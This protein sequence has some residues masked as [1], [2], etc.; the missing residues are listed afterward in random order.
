MIENEQEVIDYLKKEENKE[1]LSKNGFVTEVEKQVKTPLT[2][3]EVKGYLAG[4]PEMTKQVGATAVQAFL[5]EKLGKEVTEE[6][7]KQGLVLGGTL[8]NVKKLAIEKILSG[9][10]YGELLMAKIDFSKIQFKED[11]IEGLDEQLNSLKTQYKDL[12]EPGGTSTPPA[13]TKTEPKTDLEKVNAEL[14]ELKKK[15]NSMMNRARITLLLSKKAELEK[16]E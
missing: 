11:K 10:K 5:K 9:V 3:E 4:K 1:F 13:V 15:G 12:F 8:E 7:L 6:D 16:G 14:E 2:D